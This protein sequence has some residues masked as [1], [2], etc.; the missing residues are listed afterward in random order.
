MKNILEITYIKIQ[1]NIIPICKHDV[2]HWLPSPYIPLYTVMPCFT[3]IPRTSVASAA[4]CCTRQP[5]GC[6]VLLWGAS[7]WPI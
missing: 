7:F 2:L 6:C 5:V 1:L 3:G 4:Q